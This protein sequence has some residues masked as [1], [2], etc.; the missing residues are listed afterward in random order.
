MEGTGSICTIVMCVV[1]FITVRF[2]EL[3]SYTHSRIILGLRLL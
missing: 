3:M 2:G 1:V